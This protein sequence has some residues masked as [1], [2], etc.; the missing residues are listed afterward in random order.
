MACV[1]EIGVVALGQLADAPLGRFQRADHGVEI[2]PGVVRRA[3]VGEDDAPD[4]LD[5]LAAVDQLHRGQTQPLLVDVG[6]V[7]GEGARR[8]AAD[9]GDVTDVAGEA[10]ELIADEH[11]PHHHVLG[12]MAAA[13]VAVVVDEDV[14]GMEVL[15][16]LLLHRPFHRVRDGAHHRGGVVLLGDEVAVAIEEDGGEVEPLVEDRRVGRLQHDQ[17]HLGGDVGQGVVDDVE[18]DGVNRHGPLL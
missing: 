18:R 6:R 7:G 16:P 17:R 5:V 15:D 11:R 2:A 1:D 14:A 10:E 8:L 13:A 12:E 9:L 4:V 3:M